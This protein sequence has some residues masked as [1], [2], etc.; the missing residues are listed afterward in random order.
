MR[1]FRL[2]IRMEIAAINGATFEIYRSSF[3]RLSFWVAQGNRMFSLHRGSSKRRAGVAFLGAAAA[4]FA[5][6][7]PV[8]AAADI[9]EELS[10]LRLDCETGVSAACYAL[11]GRYEVKTDLWGAPIRGK[12]VKPDD[13]AANYYFRK[14]CELGHDKGCAKIGGVKKAGAGQAKGGIKSLRN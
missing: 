4:L 12:G 6:A 3:S 1:Y 14:A 10:E 13:G 9:L 7:A 5:L 2:R 8:P 11:G